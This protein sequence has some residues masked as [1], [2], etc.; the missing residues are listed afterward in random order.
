MKRKSPSNVRPPEVRFWE[1]V[2]KTPDCWTW[3]AALDRRGYGKIYLGN[4]KEVLAHRFSWE[5][6][7]GQI[8]K[9]MV[10]CHKCDNPSCV[11]PAHLFVGTMKDNTQDMLAKGRH[12]HGKAHGDLCRAAENRPHK[13]TPDEVL[14]IK[15]ELKKGEK[16]RAI[17]R[18]FGVCQRTVG[19]IH[20]GITW[21]HIND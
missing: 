6:H 16:Q 1:K 15:R 5:L 2:N 13:L 9:G 8:P 18:M 11:N 12:S 21:T 3:T 17:A 7:N 10:V 20:R 19:L 14:G 4:P